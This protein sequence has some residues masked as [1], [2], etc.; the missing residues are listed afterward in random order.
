VEFGY[1]YEQELY[2]GALIHDQ[3]VDSTLVTHAERVRTLLR[4]HGVK[5]AIT[6]DPHTTHMLR[7]VYPEVLGNFNVEVRSHLEILAE[8]TLPRKKVLNRNV[9]V[10]D[11]CVYARY[12]DIVD[13]PRRLLQQAGATVRVPEMS[14]RLTYCCGGPIESLFPAR[15]H[16]IA[17]KRVAQLSALTCSVATM[18]PICLVN[19]K[20][21]AD[22]DRVRYQDLAD[23]LAEA[24][25]DRPGIARGERTEE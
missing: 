10:H 5:R 14:G 20:G 12:E 15:A 11:S 23:I 6:V 7:H 1:L 18:C 13:P 16:Q 2:S 3:G 22:G 21:A 9:V 19:L 17:A 25:L 24:F 8:R 4:S